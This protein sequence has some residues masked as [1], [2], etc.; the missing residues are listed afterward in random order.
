MTD[1]I[2]Q[3]FSIRQFYTREARYLDDL[4]FDKWIQLMAPDLRYWMPIV[5]NRIGRDVGS[6]LTERG[7]L[8]QFEDDF[9]SIRNRVKR[10]A[11]GRAWAETSPG[12]SSDS[13]AGSR[14]RSG[15]PDCRA[16]FLFDPVGKPLELG[17]QILV[18]PLHYG[19]H[20][21][22]LAPDQTQRALGVFQF[23]GQRCDQLGVVLHE[24]H[25]VGQHCQ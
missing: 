16:P 8:A 2:A 18:E 15:S 6:E 21:A 12:R 7:H 3:W 22:I 10:L 14:S 25:R 13:M 9:E 5:S 24:D 11:T 1:D 4:E 20:L 19:S 23:D 17:L